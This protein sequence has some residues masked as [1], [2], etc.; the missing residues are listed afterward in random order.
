M[1]IQKGKQ[2]SICIIHVSAPFYPFIYTILI[3]SAVSIESEQVKSRSKKTA[4][5][6]HGFRIKYCS[7]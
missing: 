7:V 5:K 6:A 3:L 2:N 1:E 4:R